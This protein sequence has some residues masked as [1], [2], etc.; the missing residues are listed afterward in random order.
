[1]LKN[2][3]E[4]IKIIGLILLFI[5]TAGLVNKFTSD[6]NLS[7]EDEDKLNDAEEENNDIDQTNQILKE[8][9]TNIK[10]NI[11]NNKE[12][13]RKIKERMKEEPNGISI[14][15]SINKLRKIGKGE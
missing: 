13:I 5:L 9:S 2:I 15:D 11:D 12:T 8:K 10:Q 4:I 14:D 6:S 1:M 3:F 7:D